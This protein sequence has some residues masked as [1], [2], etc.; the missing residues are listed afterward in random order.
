[1]LHPFV[2]IV[3]NF[4]FII[5]F[6]L[7]LTAFVL[8]LP[9]NDSLCI[10]YKTVR[11]ETNILSNWMFKIERYLC[12]TGLHSPQPPVLINYLF[13]WN[14]VVSNDVIIPPR[15]TPWT[16]MG[17]KRLLWTNQRIELFTCPPRI[18]TLGISYNLFVPYK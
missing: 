11:N 12:A 15:L 3:H 17:E 7:G 8:F 5:T 16:T 10:P 4:S 1:M 9:I 6:F 13:E 2:L 18:R 14:R